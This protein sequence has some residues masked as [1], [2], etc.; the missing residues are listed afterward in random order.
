MAEPSCGI[1]GHSLSVNDQFRYIH[2]FKLNCCDHCA[3]LVSDAYWIAHSGRDLSGK[4]GRKCEKRMTAK[5]RKRILER[6]KKC[7]F[8]G[9]LENL[10]VDH[11]TPWSRGGSSSD[12]NLQVLCRKCNM[13]KGVFDNE[14]FHFY[15]DVE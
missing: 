11:I 4:D 5:I 14:Q 8:C 2:P 1:C 12:S 6:D 10:Q 9:S 15:K 3:R 7:Q 13:E